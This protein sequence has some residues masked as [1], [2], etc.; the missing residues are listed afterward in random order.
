MTRPV[1]AARPR[2]PEATP[3]AFFAGLVRPAEEPQRFRERGVAS[4]RDRGRSPAVPEFP[5]KEMLSDMESDTTHLSGVSEG[6]RRPE[7]ATSTS[8]AG[9]VCLRL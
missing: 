8:R 1:E 2:G 5:L 9:R 7:A 3:L 4:S 6:Q